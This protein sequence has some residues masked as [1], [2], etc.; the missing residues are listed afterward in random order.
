[1]SEQ[2]SQLADV[3]EESPRIEYI[4]SDE[5]N[6]QSV[7]ALTKNSPSLHAAVERLI[8]ENPELLLEE[9][10]ELRRGH[11]VV[12]L[13]LRTN[14][15]LE[16]ES[17]VSTG[18]KM[19]MSNIFGGIC[20]DEYFTRKVITDN[21]KMAAILSPPSDYVASVKE[22][23]QAGLET[24]RQILSAKVVD[25]DGFLIPRAADVVLKAYALIDMRVKGAI[26]QRIDQRTLN[27]NMNQTLAPGQITIP[28]SMED[29]DRELAELRQKLLPQP[30]ESVQRLEEGKKFLDIDIVKT[31]PG[32]SHY[33][34]NS[35]GDGDSDGE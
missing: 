19:K 33:K 9:W 30:V 21:K 25:E 22:A 1:M 12:L 16:Y 4:I 34:L 8:R 10:E 31:N 23:L 13:R 2:K 32:V 35:R 7:L 18:R 24:I 20:S 11:S 5:N 17:A 15:W 27:M 6:A 14:F 3:I 26:V 29:V 28:K